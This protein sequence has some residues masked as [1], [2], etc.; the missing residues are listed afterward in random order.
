MSEHK[1]TVSV[2]ALKE[3]THDGKAYKTG[4]T[5]DVD[6]SQVENL[7]AQGMATPAAAKPAAPAKPKP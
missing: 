5:Y 2:T 3:H 4:D 7:A 1:T 6:A